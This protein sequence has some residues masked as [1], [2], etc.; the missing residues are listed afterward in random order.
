MPRRAQ[1]DEDTAL[2]IIIVSLLSTAVMLLY[3]LLARL[4]GFDAHATALMLGATIHDVAQVA[5]ARFAVSPEVGT[6]AV[7]VKMIRVSCLLPV[8]SALGAT[9][10]RHRPPITLL[11]HCIWCRPSSSFS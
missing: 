4:I 5:A 9:F 10:L 7:T 6:Q 2:V 8:V 1:L 3:P 11:A